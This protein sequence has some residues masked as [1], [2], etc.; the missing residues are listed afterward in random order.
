MV[1][2]FPKTIIFLSSLFLLKLFLSFYLPL[3]NDEAYAVAV[4]KEYSISFFDHPPIGF[5]SSQ[6][7]VGIFGL[8][9]KLFF[10]LPFLI[11]GLFTTLFL[12]E[13]GKELKNEPLGFWT[14]LIYNLAPFYF[15]SGGLFVVPDGPLN[16]GITLVALLIVKLH[17]YPFRNDNFLLLLLG[18]SLAWCF[19]CK[20]QG[21]LIGVGCLL[22]LFFSPRR[23][24]FIKNY[25][26]YICI[27]ISIIGALPSLIWNFEN[28]WISFQFHQSRQD[29]EV[30]LIN[31]VI[32]LF[33]LMLYLLPQTVIIPF[34]GIYKSIKKEKS[35]HEVNLIL[36]ALPNLVVFL[37]VFAT[38]DRSFPHWIIPG[39][40]LLL[41]IIAKEL[42]ESLVKIKK[43]IYFGSAVSVWLIL[44]LLVIHSQTG[45]LTNN[46]DKIP[47]WDNTLELINWEP[48]HLQIDKIIRS[49]SNYKDSKIAA[50]TW[51]EA[52]QFSFLMKNKFQTLVLDSD[53]H[54]FKFMK[55][56]K[57]YGPTFLIKLSLGTNPDVR[58]LLKRIQKYDHDAFHI[59][60]LSLSRG[61]RP[62]ATASIFLFQQ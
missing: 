36:I 34:Q 38:S 10:R 9:S 13:L 42:S 12:F 11:Y 24:S 19:A 53:P 30:N 41:P 26:F 31:L 23:S 27:L 7:F 61:T 8:E 44:G 2:I 56:K 51:M 52:G 33:A 46:K 39:W 47:K 5:W 62:Y 32:T 16:L 37:V 1:N 21:Y 18:L 25:Y 57:D 17:K 28:G 60:N 22:V 48:L 45:I 14:A 29:F 3:L 55:N 40:L 54:H 15:F 35:I 59:T 58:Y 20:Y 6:I 43:T 4:S 50:F 49:Y